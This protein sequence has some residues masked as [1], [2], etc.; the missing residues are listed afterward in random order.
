ML[1]K[2]VSMNLLSVFVK[3]TRKFL[4]ENHSNADFELFSLKVEQCLLK[5]VES[6]HRNLHRNLH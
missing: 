5:Q 3:K 4:V 2:F 1:S 6:D